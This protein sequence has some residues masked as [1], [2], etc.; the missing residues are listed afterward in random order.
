MDKISNAVPASR[1]LPNTVREIRSDFPIHLYALLQR[2]LQSLQYLSP[3][4]AIIVASPAPTPQ[5]VLSSIL[6]RTVTREH[7]PL[8]SINY[9]CYC[10]DNW[11]FNH[12]RLG[13]T[14]VPLQYIRLRARS[15]A[16]ERS[17]VK[18]I[19]CARSAAINAFMT[20]STSPPA[21]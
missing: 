18:G 14:F 1:P 15:I 9:F 10:R 3:T 16:A 20:R 17:N 13:R 7:E 8:S 21:R 6:V 5:R 19:G 11:C 2:N 12:F 4:R